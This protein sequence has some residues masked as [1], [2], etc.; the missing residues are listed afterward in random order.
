MY[1]IQYLCGGPG[2]VGATGAGSGFTWTGRFGTLGRCAGRFLGTSGGFLGGFS[3]TA[4]GFVG[5]GGSVGTGGIFGGLSTGFFGF[6][7]GRL[8]GF[9]GFCWGRSG[10]FGFD[11]G[12]SIFGFA[13]LS[14][15]MAHYALH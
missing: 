11:G 13:G 15:Q 14:L 10:L 1:I 9:F 8:G 5:A 3:V 12:G 6:A 2:V 7:G 4:G